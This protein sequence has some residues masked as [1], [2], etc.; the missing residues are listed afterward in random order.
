MSLGNNS[1]SSSHPK[2]DSQT[3]T[4]TVLIPNVT[5]DINILPSHP[6]PNPQTLFIALSIPIRSRAHPNHPPSRHTHP[7]V[8]GEKHFPAI[9]QAAGQ[10]PFLSELPHPSQHSVIFPLITQT[11]LQPN[12]ISQQLSKHE[13]NAPTTPIPRPSGTEVFPC[14]SSSVTQPVSRQTVRAQRCTQTIAQSKGP[15]PAQH[16]FRTKRNPLPLTGRGSF[17]FSA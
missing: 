6:Q 5:P 9:S 17:G 2:A 12:S 1:Q 7:A 4:H 10:S 14:I 3:S 8:K 16:P 15:V 13:G 11:V